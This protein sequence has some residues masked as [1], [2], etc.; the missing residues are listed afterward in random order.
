MIGGVRV[1]PGQILLLL[2]KSQSCA[3]TAMQNAMENA[4]R[5]EQGYYNFAFQNRGLSTFGGVDS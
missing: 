3:A 4:G 1:S 2:A 5:V